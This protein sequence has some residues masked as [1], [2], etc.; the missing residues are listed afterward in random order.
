M[1]I[2]VNELTMLD[3]APA[4]DRPSFEKTAGSATAKDPTPSAHPDYDGLGITD[5]DIPF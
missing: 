5:D 2:I 3:G 1:E 4:A